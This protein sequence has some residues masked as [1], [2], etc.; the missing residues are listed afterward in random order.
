MITLK[1]SM[2][3]DLGSVTI[4]SK[5]TSFF[6]LSF[7][8]DYLLKINFNTS[9]NADELN[10]NETIEAWNTIFLQNIFPSPLDEMFHSF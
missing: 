6:K 8:F 2:K 5:M 10:L 4:H 3:K 7:N 9:V 1:S